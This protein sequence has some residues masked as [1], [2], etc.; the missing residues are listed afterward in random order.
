MAV[1]PSDA[2]MFSG[3]KQVDLMSVLAE[4]LCEISN[5]SLHVGD[6]CK[7]ECLLDTT[8][9]STLWVSA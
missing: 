4:Q 8:M 9:A 1:E 3:L 2:F 5:I 7:D 6:I